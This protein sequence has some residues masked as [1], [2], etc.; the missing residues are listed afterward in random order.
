MSDYKICLAC[1]AV[2][3]TYSYK[4]HYCE[5]CGSSRLSEEN[6]YGI[7][8][9]RFKYLGSEFGRTHC[10]YEHTIPMIEQILK[11]LIH[12]KESNEHM[13]KAIANSS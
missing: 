13:M 1:M 6:E 10:G 8:S 7:I 2:Y 12:I 4:K 9:K 3:S 5:Q 11:E